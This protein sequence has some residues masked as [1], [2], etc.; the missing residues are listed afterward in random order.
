MGTKSIRH[1]CEAAVATYL[2]AQTEFAGVEINTGD[3]ATL[4][5]LPRIICL[6]PSAGP[7]PD[8]PEG[9]GNFLATME[10]HVCSSADD[11]TLLNHR[12]RCSAVAGFMDSTTDLGAVF[13]TAGD[14]HLYDI[15]PLPETDEHESRIWHT[16]LSFSLYT[17][18]P[19]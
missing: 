1:I 4:Q 3:S 15:S 18:L 11:T 5:T 9:L 16:N 8:L 12:A 6:C 7:M 17:V 10:V 13:T 19:A 2:S 14:A